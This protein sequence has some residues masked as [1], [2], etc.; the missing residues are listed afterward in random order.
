MA[1][2]PVRTQHPPAPQPQQPPVSSSD[3]SRRN[4]SMLVEA[5]RHL[6][7]DSLFS[8]G[9]ADKVA[10]AAC[11]GDCCQQQQT[12]A[13]SSTAVD[14]VVAAPAAAVATPLRTSPTPPTPTL[15]CAPQP[16]LRVP[17][18]EEPEH[19]RH[20]YSED[21]AG[22]RSDYST[23]RDSP[24]PPLPRV[25]PFLAPVAPARVKV[26]HQQP[27]APRLISPVVTNGGLALAQLPVGAQVVPLATAATLGGAGAVS[28]QHPVA[29][30]LL[31]RPSPAL[32]QE[33]LQL[34]Q[35]PSASGN[36][37]GPRPGVIVHK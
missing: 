11:G 34:T 29:V 16:R 21:E 8:G 22:V 31:H 24:S 13:P 28:A 20:L 12:P 17:D 4:L 30:Q 15:L 33:F 27:L 7:G 9:G 3:V 19:E 1:P 26:T 36:R 2:P 37:S 23:G 5:L 18:C 25:E 14:V 35:G 10:A 32:P 6:E